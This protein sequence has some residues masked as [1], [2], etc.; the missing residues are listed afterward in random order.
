M[1]MEAAQSFLDRLKTDEDFAKKV[2]EF[3]TKE[4]RIAYVSSVGY[5]FTP[6]E[7]YNAMGEL[8]DD[9][10]DTVVGGHFKA[11]CTGFYSRVTAWIY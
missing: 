3:P 5:E 8:N 7:F 2:G 4:E 6:D 11:D 1:S 10:L 9:H